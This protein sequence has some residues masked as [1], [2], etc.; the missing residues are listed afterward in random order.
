VRN[1]L[2]LKEKEILSK[3]DSNLQESLE[4]LEKGVKI[5]IKRI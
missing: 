3:C 4:D 5:I 1:I 2:S